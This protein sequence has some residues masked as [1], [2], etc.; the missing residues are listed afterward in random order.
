[1]RLMHMCNRALCIFCVGVEDIGYAFVHQKLLVHR[2]LQILDFAIRAEDLAQVALV[3]ILC[4]LFDDD[5]GRL[6]N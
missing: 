2:H 3:H 6:W 1:M 5:L 4:E